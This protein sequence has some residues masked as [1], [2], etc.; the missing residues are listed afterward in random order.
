[1]IVLFRMNLPTTFR[2]FSPKRR[3]EVTLF[4]AA[5]RWVVVVVVV[6]VVFSK[7]V[8]AAEASATWSDK[9]RL[10][11]HRFFGSISWKMFFKRFCLNEGTSGNYRQET[12]NELYNSC[13]NSTKDVRTSILLHRFCRK[14][15]AST[16]YW[17][18]NLPNRLFLSWHH[19]L[20]WD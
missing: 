6:V 11:R 4:R 7:R 10:T 16:G 8:V 3:R 1:M 13:R 19:H 15:F 9:L 18:H 2:F 17:T 12:I 20:S 14:N 5:T